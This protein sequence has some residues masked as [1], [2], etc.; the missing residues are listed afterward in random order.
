MKG[1]LML[2]KINHSKSTRPCDNTST[3][4]AKTRIQKTLL[5]KLEVLVVKK[6][7]QINPFIKWIYSNTILMSFLICIL[8][9]IKLFNFMDV[10]E[11]KNDRKIMINKIGE[12]RISQGMKQSEFANTL[13]VSQGT[14][15][16]V[17]K[18]IL[19]PSFT[20]MSNLSKNFNY[21]VNELFVSGALLANEHIITPTKRV[22][23]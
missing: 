22:S 5:S 20:F 19:I 9:W 7:V 2:S 10:T 12:F 23:K 21:D 11:M 3:V 6:N 1:S 14:V 18:G 13:Q 8:F 4:I 16:K 17:E 15:S